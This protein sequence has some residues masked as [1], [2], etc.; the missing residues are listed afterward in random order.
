MRVHGVLHLRYAMTFRYRP[1]APDIGSGACIDASRLDFDEL[2]DTP[3]PGKPRL[4]VFAA[5]LLV[6]AMLGGLYALSASAETVEDLRGDIPTG[7][8]LRSQ[9]RDI[10]DER[11][12]R[13]AA[14]T[15]AE[16]K[17]V[18]VL[19]ERESLADDQRRLV[20]EIEAATVNLKRL[21]V[22]VFITGG[23]TGSLEYLTAVN[24]ANDVA[25]RRYLVRS[26][27]G[28][29]RVA[30]DRLRDLRERADSLVLDTIEIAEDLRAEIDIYAAALDVLADSEAEIQAVMPVA[31]AWDRAA[32]AIA[33]GQY[34]IAPA[35][36]WE[37]LRS[38]ESTDNY[39]A[40][41]P[42]G[43]YRGAYQFDLTT[44]ETVGG[45][46]DPAL[47]PPEEQDAR[48]RELYARR[49]SQPWPVCGMHLE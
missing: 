10:A 26:H 36:K 29:S 33:S 38:C 46:G 27:A 40:I 24:G 32:I 49:G 18:D 28:S 17:L 14:L 8:Q 30:I 7:D 23:D 39:Q 16:A 3:R 47:A 43:L 1:P 11:A 44:W 31:D 4:R 25:W 12:A 15:S 20:A 2:F 35:D 41:S 34:G 21:A 37:T 9:L 5:L 45:T 42:S 48:A 19:S 22:Q 13:L 6:L